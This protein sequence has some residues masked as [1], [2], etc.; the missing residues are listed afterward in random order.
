MKTQEEISIKHDARVIKEWDTH[1]PEN[2]GK[3]AELK[4]WPDEELEYIAAEL[5]SRTPEDQRVFLEHYVRDEE[6]KRHFIR[7]TLVDTIAISLTE[8]EEKGLSPWQT[9]D[10]EIRECETV[11]EYYEE[12]RN[13]LRELLPLSPNLR[14]LD[15]L[16]T[17]Y[18]VIPAGVSYDRIVDIMVEKLNFTGDRKTLRALVELLD[19]KKWLSMTAKGPCVI[20]ANKTESAKRAVLIYHYIKEE[21][22]KKDLPAHPAREIKPTFTYRGESGLI[23][24]DSSDIRK[25]RTALNPI[26]YPDFFT[27]V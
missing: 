25:A 7:K 20:G 17:K 10:A 15:E 26:T 23:Y 13:E 2:Y 9:I 3:P 18:S 6:G 4:H 24:F 16:F 22:E 5:G 1:S 27:T 8:P 19:D 21:I 11:F 14:L 12:Y